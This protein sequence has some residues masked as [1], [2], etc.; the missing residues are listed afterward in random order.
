MAFAFVELFERELLGRGAD[1][2]AAVE[3]LRPV[4]AQ[5]VAA[6]FDQAM[7]AE[8]G[9]RLSAPASRG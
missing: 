8:A 1:P 2:V 4:A 5:T 6:L 9:R 3:G 7:A